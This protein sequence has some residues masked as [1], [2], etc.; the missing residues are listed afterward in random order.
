M[1][2]QVKYCIGLPI[3][4][5]GTISSK[6]SRLTGLPQHPV[7]HVLPFPSPPAIC[8]PHKSPQKRLRH[9]KSLQI[10]HKILQNHHQ[11]H[12]GEIRCQ[13]NKSPLEFV[14]RRWGCYWPLARNNVFSFPLELFYWQLQRLSLMH[15]FCFRLCNCLCLCDVFVIVCVF[16]RETIGKELSLALSEAFAAPLLRTSPLKHPSDSRL[17]SQG[18][19]VNTNSKSFLPRHTHAQRYIQA[20][21]IWQ[22]WQKEHLRCK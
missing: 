3:H 19:K 12:M 1:A 21:T 10:H 22:S 11:N 16:V 7:S 5:E 13:R 4:S 2:R 17:I 18:E 14:F 20:Y 9:Q 8:E 6:F 15:N